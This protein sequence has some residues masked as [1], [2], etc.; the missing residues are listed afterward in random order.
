M[1]LHELKPRRRLGSFRYALRGIAT[2][3]D[4][5][6]NAWVHFSGLILVVVFGIGFDISG[7]EWAAVALAC[8]GV[9]AAEALNSAI[10][11]LANFACKNERHPQIARVKDLAAA[12]VLLA[13][14]GAVGVGIV[15]FGVRI[16]DLFS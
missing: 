5:T 13:A 9:F 10:E 7:G 8:G 1:E 3:M 11:E 4:T 16:F 12:G 14:F 6:P 2:L 15:V